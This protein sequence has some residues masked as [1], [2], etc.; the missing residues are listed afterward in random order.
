MAAALDDEQFL[1]ED[2]AHDNLPDS[3][4]IHEISDDEVESV[5]ENNAK[6]LKLAKR[7]AKFALMKEKKKQKVDKS[8]KDEDPQMVPHCMLEFLE[9][10]RATVLH[11]DYKQNNF[12]EDNLLRCDK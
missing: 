4:D 6:Q 2:L 5:D 9:S 8:D 11:D 1:A 10:T 3:N 7:K 12:E